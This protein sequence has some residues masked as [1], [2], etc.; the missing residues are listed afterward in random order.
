M[1]LLKMKSTEN[2]KKAE[3][4]KN[5][6]D[7]AERIKDDDIREQFK[8]DTLPTKD[9]E[10]KNAELSAEM[11]KHSNNNWRVKLY[12]RGPSSAYNVRI[13]LTDDNQFLD[14]GSLDR[15]LPL[16]ELEEGHSV[17]LLSSVHLGS[18]LKDDIVI[19]W[20]D[21]VSKDRTKTVTLTL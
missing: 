3:L 20:D 5:L 10:A 16:R 19:I 2:N 17:E 9:A 18:H 13:E 8:E 11:Y 14:S 4:A 15:I 7:D 1:K 6:D 21:D 12:N